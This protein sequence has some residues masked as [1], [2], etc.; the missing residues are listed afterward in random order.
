M[1]RLRT[2][3]G[4]SALALAVGIGGTAWLC[5]LTAGWAGPPARTAV[6]HTTRVPHATKVP[7][8]P[9]RARWHGPVSVVQERRANVV[10]LAADNGGAHAAVVQAV[11]ALVPLTTPA[12]VSQPYYQLR[13]HLDG[14]VLV[15]LDLDEYGGVVG[16]RVADSSGDPLLDQ[17]AL[18][19][20]RG[21]RFAVTAGDRARTSGDLPMR[22]SSVGENGVSV[23]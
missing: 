3:T 6:V 8:E 18:R 13:G 20:V 9:Q 11:P 21:W 16:A 4:L 14:R 17:H 12:D 15:H 2:T 7:H 5:T 23:R 19:S 1:L 10:H 22:F